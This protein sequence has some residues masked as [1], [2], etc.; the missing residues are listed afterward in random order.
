MDSFIEGVVKSMTIDEFKTFLEE[1]QIDSKNVQRAIT[2][3][4]DFDKSN[5]G[6]SDDSKKN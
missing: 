6:S 4:Y 1:M 2:S 5:A 3:N